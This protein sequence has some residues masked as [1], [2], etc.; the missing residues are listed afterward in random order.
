MLGNYS[1][2]IGSLVGF[3]AGVAVSYGLPAELATPEIQLSLTGL[4]VGVA[5]WAFPKNKP[6]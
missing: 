2:L 3:V 1:K 6:V 4:L 5:T